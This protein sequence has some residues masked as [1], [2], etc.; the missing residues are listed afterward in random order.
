MAGSV[1]IAVVDSHSL[2]RSGV[3]HTLASVSDYTVVAEGASQEDASRIAAQH[4]PDIL[5]LDLH[6]SFNADA[7]K[8]LVAEFPAMRIIM[9]TM[10]AE[11]GQVVAALQAGAAGYVL[12]GLSGAELIESIR[13]V[14]RGESYVDPSL[15]AMLLSRPP[16][17]EAKPDPV[18]TLTTREEQVWDCLTQGLNNKEIARKLDLAPSTVKHYMTELFEK[19]QVRNRVEAAILAHKRASGLRMAPAPIT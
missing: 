16:R 7:L 6:F 14:H 13:R 11:E 3:I 17:R 1:R 8:R 5:L 4:A 12:K 15:A 19:L 10:V 2:F 9:L 18:S